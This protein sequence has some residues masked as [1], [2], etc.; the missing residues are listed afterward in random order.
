[1]SAKRSLSAFTSIARNMKR[2]RD[3]GFEPEAADG[4]TGRRGLGAGMGWSFAATG[5]QQGIGTLVSFVLAILLGPHAYGLV[6]IA[7]IYITFVQLALNQGIAAAIVQRKDLEASHLDSA[8]WLN[9]A[10]AIVLTG[11]SIG[12][13]GVWA[14]INHSDELTGIIYALSLLIPIQALTIVQ[15]AILVRQLNFKKL[16][17]RSNFAAV[18]GGIAGIV[19]AV[20]GAGVW[21]LVVQQ[22]VMAVASL[23][24]LWVVSRWVPR[25]RFS[26]SHARDLLGFSVQVFAGNVAVFLDQRADA[27]MM[28]I[29]FGPVA[30]GVY[31][32]A[33][34]LVDTFVRLSARPVMTFALAHFSRLQD[35]P[36]GLREAVRDCMRLNAFA[37]MPFMLGLAACSKE[38]AGVLGSQWTAAPN[39]LRLL[40]VVGLAK[41]F[42]GYAA[43]LLFAVGKPFMRAALQWILAAVSAS[44]F[45]GVAAALQSGSTRHQVLGIATSRVALFCLIFVPVNL[46]IIRRMTG[47]TSRSL[48]WAART[49]FFSGVAAIVAVAAAERLG[50]LDM[51]HPVARLVIAVVIASTVLVVS[52]IGLDRSVRT[53]ATRLART[54]LGRGL[55][56]VTES[57]AGGQ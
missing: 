9:L 20:E 55:P 29:F 52:L 53:L 46:L 32:L 54:A 48:L 23:L 33:D 13:G 8:F 40:T 1:V 34:R 35:D 44:T 30:V 12:V 51:P 45:A 17:L 3:L 37:T 43:A 47:I 11:V 21:A 16:A 18:I 57:V 6:A 56:P 4:E 19:A 31:R 26:V 10:W 2:A 49:P 41:V 15:Q 50:L 7:L 39:V 24:V 42:L 25:M 28:G 36:E 38:L 22:L 27:M 5:G 14:S